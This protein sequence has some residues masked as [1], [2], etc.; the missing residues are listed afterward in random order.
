MGRVVNAMMPKGLFRYQLRP[1]A[2]S[3]YHLCPERDIETALDLAEIVIPNPK[4]TVLVTGRTYTFSPEGEITPEKKKILLD[5]LSY[6]GE[7]EL[8]KVP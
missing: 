8:I 2:G 5:S 1:K 4:S 3:Q 6:C 7:F